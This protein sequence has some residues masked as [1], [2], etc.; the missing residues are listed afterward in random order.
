MP[1]F[2]D[3]A[4]PLAKDADGER[5]FAVLTVNDFVL[6]EEMLGKMPYEVVNPVMGS[7]RDLSNRQWIAGLAAAVDRAC[8]NHRLLASAEN[9][10]GVTN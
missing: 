9:Y 6:L 5:V 2:S 7:L 4:K 3:L 8:R 10:D 1:F